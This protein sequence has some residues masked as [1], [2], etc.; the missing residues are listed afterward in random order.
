MSVSCGSVSFGGPPQHRPGGLGGALYIHDDE[1]LDQAIHVHHAGYRSLPHKS[2]RNSGNFPIST[3]NNFPYYSSTVS[4]PRARV[5]QA[6]QPQ[7]SVKPDSSRGS[8]LSGLE[9]ANNTV[10]VAS[11]NRSE[12][13]VIEQRRASNSRFVFVF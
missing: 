10:S 6:Q 11:D 1:D 7:L 13:T 12:S 3:P 4:T 8:L 5:S 9:T 2:Q